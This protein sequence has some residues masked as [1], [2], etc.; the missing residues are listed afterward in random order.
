MPTRK[1]LES[2]TLKELCGIGIDTDVKQPQPQGKLSE[3]GE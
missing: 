3:P 2:Q 1:K